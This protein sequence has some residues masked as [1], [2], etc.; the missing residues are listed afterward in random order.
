[1][2][3]PV[4]ADSLTPDQ[5]EELLDRLSTICE[6]HGADEDY[7]PHA[8]PWDELIEQEFGLPELGS[9][10]SRTAY[11]VQVDGRPPAVLKVINGPDGIHEQRHELL[12]L[13]AGRGLSV[14][15]AVHRWGPAD[16]WPCWMLVEYLRD[17][18]EE[19]WERAAGVSFDA[20][21]SALGDC[22]PEDDED[23]LGPPCVRNRLL[24]YG[25]HPGFA[26][27]VQQAV[28]ICRTDTAELD[29]DEHWGA[30][31]EGRLKIRDLGSRE[32]AA[33]WAQEPSTEL[34]EAKRRLL[35]W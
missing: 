26:E 35:S 27:G 1:V 5:L 18:E 9:G 30:D 34:V 20:F 4:D 21:Q 2:P 12:C 13:L 25:A 19:D 14:V 15:P 31:V 29:Q 33:E 24:A 8:A 17:A 22:W 16:G 28:R 3:S 6:K 10:A 7:P 11:L 32:T 23:P